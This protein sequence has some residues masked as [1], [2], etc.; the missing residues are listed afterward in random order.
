MDTAKDEYVSHTDA[1][2]YTETAVAEELGSKSV[3]DYVDSALLEG[4]DDDFGSHTG[5]SDDQ[6][7]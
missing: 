1:D 3:S 2:E 6:L 4:M 5:K 7:Q